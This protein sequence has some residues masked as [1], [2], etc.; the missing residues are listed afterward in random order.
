MLRWQ[1]HGA[2][3]TFS[4]IQ[5]AACST[6]G[7]VG[8]RKLMSPAQSPRNYTPACRRRCMEP[9]VRVGHAVVVRAACHTRFDRSC[10]LHTP[11]SHAVYRL[12]IVGRL[13]PRGEA[14]LLV[15]FFLMPLVGR[16]LFWMYQHRRPHRSSQAYAN[17]SDRTS[18][19]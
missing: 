3:N 11:A 10:A 18:D 15:P 1:Q 8:P 14:S 5:L 13:M 9:L 4:A 7:D 6:A 17:T 16:K 2:K 12:L 19:G